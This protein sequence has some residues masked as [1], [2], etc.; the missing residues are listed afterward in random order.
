[1]NEIKRLELITLAVQYCQKVKEKG[2]PSSCFSKA[3]R[4]PIH[5][6]WETR[7]GP[8]YK[9]AQY[10]SKSAFAEISG[11]GKI[12]YD[13]SIPFRYLQDELL[14]LD[15]V[16]NKTVKELLDLYSTVCVITKDEDNLL[17]SRGLSRKMPNDWDNEDP[18]ARYKAVG[19][20]VEKN[21]F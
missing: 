1:M 2:M 11:N 20:E 5:F 15:D 14:N 6:L 3:L 13:H 16:N 4:E 10:R 9:V 21:E 7:N 12:I 18:L 17:S 19:I 8:K